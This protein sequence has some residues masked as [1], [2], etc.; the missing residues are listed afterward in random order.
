[1][2]FVTLFLIFCFIMLLC[3][4]SL[5]SVKN[6][7]ALEIWVDWLKFRIKRGP[8][9]NWKKRRRRLLRLLG[10]L[11]RRVKHIRKTSGKKAAAKALDQGLEELS[12]DPGWSQLEFSEVHL[13]DE[14][15]DKRLI[16]LS[17]EFGMKPS[18][19]INQA[20]EDWADTKAAYRLFKN[21]KVSP[22]KILSPHQNRVQERMADYPVVLGIQDT[23]FL[24]YTH[25]PE[26]EGLGPIG[27]EEQHLSGLVM[28]STLT[29]APNGLPLGVLTQH[30]WARDEEQGIAKKRKDR[31]IEEKESFKWI[32][33][34]REAVPFIPAKTQFVSVCDREADI[35][36]YL[37]E[38]NRLDIDFLIRAA[39]NRKVTAEI[40]R[41]WTF[42]ESQD[43]EEYFNLH[44]PAR[45]DRRERE[46]IISVRFSQITLS[47]P[48]RNRTARNEKLM[49]IQ[50]WAV[51][52]QEVEP[53]ADVKEPIEWMLLTSLP[54]RNGSEALR[55]MEW[56]STRWQIEV[57]HK[58]LKSGCKVEDCRLGT[59]DRLCSYLTLFSVIAWRLFW[60]THISRTN[61]D[62]PATMVMADHEWKALYAIIHKTSKMPEHV[63]TVYQV[64]RWTAQL[65][66]FLARKNDKEPGVT[67]I[68]RGWNRLTDYAKIWKIVNSNSPNKPKP[69]TYG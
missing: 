25:H 35:Y 61:P 19:P 44:V 8:A 56:Y 62:A 60:M 51:L 28:H 33:A 36:E 17:D 2:K 30:I 49:P 53:A 67:V 41:L 15:L 23:T 63:P 40:D 22:E 58:V 66:G 42:M 12:T 13:G 54:I 37:C 27:T 32:E 69:S 18:A 26:T 31:P 52:A 16:K 4:F 65:G 6:Y 50:V 9:R 29:V 1:M 14:R 34:L 24:N 68:W 20:C 43:I 47:P 38:A 3:S 64:V 11:R 45:K 57:Y 48:R 7:Y 59:A 46:A 10:R 39:Q 21:K 55:C 5:S